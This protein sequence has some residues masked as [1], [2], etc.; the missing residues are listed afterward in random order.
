MHLITLRGKP[1]ALAGADRCW[2]APHIEQLP[3]G[4]PDKRRV[5]FMAFYARDVITGALP[6][7]F[8]EREA[9]RFAD[10]ADVADVAGGRPFMAGA[11]AAVDRSWFG[12]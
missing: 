12:R 10:L 9:E 1:A 3:T 4:H 8:S 7:P 6:G 11:R 5:A 2:L